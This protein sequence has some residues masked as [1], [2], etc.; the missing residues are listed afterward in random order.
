MCGFPDKVAFVRLSEYVVVVV[1][2]VVVALVVRL[3]TRLL[4]GFCCW[5]CS[6]SVRLTFMSWLG[7][8]LCTVV[9]GALPLEDGMS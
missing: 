6:A 1:V 4:V 3:T 5:H 9:C 7:C 2:V 8:L